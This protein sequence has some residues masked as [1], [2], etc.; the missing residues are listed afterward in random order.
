[1]GRLKLRHQILIILGVFLIAAGI[2]FFLRQRDS[3]ASDE[4]YSA[5]LEESKLPVIW[6]EINGRKMNVMRGHIGD[7]GYDVAYDTLTLLPEDR[8]LS[9]YVTDAA[10]NVTGARFEVR[11][12]N[13]TSLIEQTE[14][15]A[16][17]KTEDGIH[18]IIPVQNLL[19]KDS[20][21]RL[22]VILNTEE[23]GD[24]HYYTRIMLT[25]DTAL[26]DE[27]L[28][29]VLG[30]SERNFNYD[31]ARENTMYVETD[32]SADDTQLEYTNLKS[33]FS[34]LAYNSLK[35]VPGSEKDL[36]LNV[37]DGNTGEISLGFIAAREL[38]SGVTEYYEI[39]ESYTLRM[40]AVR[41]YMMNYSRTMKEIFTGASSMSSRR[42]LLGIE[43][44]DDIEYLNSPDSRITYFKLTG[45]LWGYDSGS[46]SV[47]N[48]FSF[49]NNSQTGYVDGYDKHDIKL[50][51]C[52]EAG[53]LSFIVYG[54]MNRGMHEGETGVSYMFYDKESDTVK[55]EFFISVAENFGELK[56]DLGEL[57]Y[58]GDNDMLYVMIARNVYSIDTKSDSLMV[59]AENLYH[60]SYAIAKN[61]Q[62]I[63][64][65]GVSDPFGCDVINILDLDSGQKQEVR[66]DAGALLKPEG[67]IGRDLV[68][69]LREEKDIWKLNGRAYSIP[70]VAIEIIDDD[71]NVLKR[72]EK[73]GVKI[74]KVDVHDGRVNMS[75]LTKKAG[76]YESAGEDTLV[77]STESPDRREGIGSYNTD[78]KLRV[79]YIVIGEELSRGQIKVAARTKI[80]DTEVVIDT[81]KDTKAATFNAYAEGELKSSCD[82][83]VDAVKIAYDNMGTVRYKGAVVYNRSGSVT[84]RLIDDY[85]S[86][87]DTLMESYAKGELYPLTGLD[88]KQVLY[89]VSEGH[90]VLAFTDEGVP[91]VIYYYDR[92]QVSLYY[93]D[94]RERE[95][96]DLESAA[97]MFESGHNDFLCFLS[98]D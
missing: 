24:V 3:V 26:A 81:I 23:K 88:L 41:L 10:V 30:F 80:V 86:Q 72:Y 48:I 87:T 50:L 40:G 46:R 82:N 7:V 68:L 42:I 60:G 66:S 69:S 52:D 32:G 98:F 4:V 39:N 18:L 76:G 71:L 90:P 58:L 14:V 47:K 67:Y 85:V 19:I 93:P 53:N 51:D 65:Q 75:L 1:M 97:Q 77:S 64:W 92:Q 27:M 35:L 37:Y 54:Y 21:Y 49:R 22:D 13:L 25:D 8:R 79:Y 17:T 31:S 89:F 73:D 9:L 83:L 45:D 56:E 5:T 28:D 15:E 38:S 94:T 12:A 84:S 33:T 61:M 63:A 20:E 57:S 2:F 70:A 16:F 62:K 29:L 78:D 6:A 59:I 11:N 36:R 95:Y 43:D 96:P 91:C 34:N 74:G 44:E 55:E